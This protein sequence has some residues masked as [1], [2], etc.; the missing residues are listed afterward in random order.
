MSYCR[1]LLAEHSEE[2]L[3]VKAAVLSSAAQRSVRWTPQGRVRTPIADWPHLQQSLNDGKTYELGEGDETL[4]RLGDLIEIRDAETGA[5]VSIRSMFAVPMMIAR[6]PVGLLSVGELAARDHTFRELRLEDKNLIASIATQA[7]FMIDREWRMESMQRAREGVHGLARALALGDQRDALRKI[8][9]AIL[10]ATRSDIVTLYT[11]DPV[12]REIVGPATTTPLLQPALNVRPAAVSA[13][14][15]VLS[16]NELYSA[17][18]VSGDAILGGAFVQRENVTS[19]LGTPIWLKKSDAED[20]ADGPASR[21]TVGVLFVN[22]RSR[23]TFTKEDAEIVNMFAHLAAVTI[24][25]K[26]LFE[27]ERRKAL[28]EEAL[29][30][31]AHILTQT[32]SIDDPVQMDLHQT[33]QSVVEQARNVA[34]ACGRDVTSVVVALL[35]DRRYTHFATWPEAYVRDRRAQLW[36]LTEPLPDGRAAEV[37][38]VANSGA[39][40]LNIARTVSVRQFETV[41]Q[42]T[43]SQLLVAVGESPYRDGV[44]VVESSNPAGLEEESKQTF[45]FFSTLAFDAIRTARHRVDLLR[46][47]ARERDSADLAFFYIKSGVLVHRHKGDVRDVI[48]GAKLLRSR[49]DTVGVP[50][51]LQRD[52]DLFEEAVL[53]LNDLLSST[54]TDLKMLPALLNDI[55][56]DWKT[57]LRQQREYDAIELRFRTESTKG[58]KVRVDADLLREVFAILCSNA[59]KAM[60]TSQRKQLTV[61]TSTTDEKHCRIAFIDTGKGIDPAELDVDGL[62]LRSDA[63]RARGTGYGIPTAELIMKRFEGE[64]LKPKTGSDGTTNTVVL[65]IIV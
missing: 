8:V 65:P 40:K 60:A 54:S 35:E 5:H 39:A 17:D 22:Y 3:T 44:I 63:A 64:I 10:E 1:I 23:H 42:E 48:S 58:L 12:H 49:A 13:V 27:R 21:L 7:T 31:A 29:R 32:R 25:N 52:F 24:R 16:H 41:H 6:R 15:R 55:L 9:D 56:L 57:R 46:A 43:L 2:F 61:E 38:E 36:R 50:P 33:L 14:G 34:M 28:T 30:E 45:E 4:V 26:D 11:I 20:G 19:S 62:F 37:T 53:T 51:Q 18:D 59:R 47:R